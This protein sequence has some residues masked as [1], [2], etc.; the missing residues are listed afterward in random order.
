MIAAAI[1][2]VAFVM[3]LLLYMKYEAATTTWQ[4]HYW[5][6]LTRLWSTFGLIVLFTLVAHT[7]M[8][9]EYLE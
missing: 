6:V 8:K 7:A 9:W 5:S 3:Y 1:I 4:F 2:A